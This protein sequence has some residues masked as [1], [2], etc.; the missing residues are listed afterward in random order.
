[1]FI[2]YGKAVKISSSSRCSSWD[3]RRT[4]LSVLSKQTMM[5]RSISA[6][7]IK[8]RENLH[9]LWV[10]DGTF[11]AWRSWKAGYFQRVP[12][13]FHN[14]VLWE[15]A[16]LYVTVRTV[17]SCQ[18][19]FLTNSQV[20][21]IIVL[22]LRHSMTF[23]LRDNNPKTHWHECKNNLSNN[24]ELFYYDLFFFYVKNH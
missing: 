4:L 10:R 16:G 11:M 14:R 21:Q 3:Q 23:I 7:L 12:W 6:G 1:M 8:K 24:A 18:D 19:T 15:R 17:V 20:F 9:M 13:S 2:V 5:D 22:Q